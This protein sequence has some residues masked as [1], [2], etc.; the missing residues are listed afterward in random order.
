VD[1]EL[2]PR[3][4]SARLS[5]FSCKL[6][7]PCHTNAQKRCNASVGDHTAIR[8][9][10]GVGMA[11]LTVVSALSQRPWWRLFAPFQCVSS[12]KTPTCKAL[13]MQPAVPASTT[14]AVHWQRADHGMNIL[15]H[16]LVTRTKLGCSSCCDRGCF[17]VA[18]TAA[19]LG[20]S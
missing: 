5:S 3:P 11:A 15:L 8:P 6:S 2:N 12:S 17:V 16:I 9:R 4:F 10:R 14:S 19:R 1:G 13:Q 7:H 20:S 18:S